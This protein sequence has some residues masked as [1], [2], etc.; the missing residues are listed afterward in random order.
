MDGGRISRFMRQFRRSFQGRRHH[1][2]ALRVEEWLEKAREEQSETPGE[3]AGGDGVEAIF[4]EYA[5]STSGSPRFNHEVGT[6]AAY[7]KAREQHVRAENRRRAEA[8]E[9]AELLKPIEEKKEEED[10]EHD[11]QFE[12]PLQPEE[13]LIRPPMIAP[14][15]HNVFLPPGAGIQYFLWTTDNIIEWLLQFYPNDHVMHIIRQ[16]EIIGVQ[17][18]SCFLDPE[19]SQDWCDLNGIS[20]GSATRIRMVLGKIH[21]IFYKYDN[22]R[23][24]WNR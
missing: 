23:V 2:D 5:Q 22:T 17:L 20:D 7:A 1:Q 18:Y 6:V 11:G 15:V 19:T 14:V 13:T 24:R 9:E 21:N 8:M 12:R 4:E 10:E 3:P 16:D